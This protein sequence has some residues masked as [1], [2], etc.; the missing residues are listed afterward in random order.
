MLPGGAYYPQDTPCCNLVVCDLILT[1]CLM[2]LTGIPVAAAEVAAPIHKLWV[3]YL[4][5]SC[6]EMDLH[7]LLVPVKNLIKYTTYN[8]YIS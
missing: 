8:S 2:V 5:C 7:T 4:L 3:L 1:S 6:T